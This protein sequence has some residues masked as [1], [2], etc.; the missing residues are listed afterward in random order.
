MLL[1]LIPVGL[2]VLLIAFLWLTYNSLVT[3]KTRVDESWAGIDVQLKRRSSL[4][5]NLVETVKGYASHEKEVFEQVTAARSSLMQAESPHEKAAADNM[6]SGTLKSLFAVSENYPELKANENFL[7]LQRDLSDTEDKIAYARQFY[8]GNVRD[9]N[10]KTRTFPNV[11][12]AGMFGFN[13]AE[14]YEAEESAKDDVSV[15]FTPE[16]PAASA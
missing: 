3:S 13:P 10:I 6:L 11:L 4:I 12:L 16:K 9:Y 1:I 14:F 8:N 7:S 5:P 15:S 2:L